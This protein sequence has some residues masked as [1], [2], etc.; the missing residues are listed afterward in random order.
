MLKV[1]RWSKVLIFY[2]VIVISLFGTLKCFGNSCLTALVLKFPPNGLVYEKP[3]VRAVFHRL[4]FMSD[5]NLKLVDFGMGYPDFK[6]DA[7]LERTD[8]LVELEGG[9]SVDFNSLITLS[10]LKKRFDVDEI[11]LYDQYGIDHGIRAYIVSSKIKDSQGNYTWSSSFFYFKGE[12]M[13]G[14]GTACF[15]KKEERYHAL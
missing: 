12:V 10:S 13:V 1:K 9:K 3:P 8:V 14:F 11:T 15:S 7:S 2:F 4:F 5:R 6:T